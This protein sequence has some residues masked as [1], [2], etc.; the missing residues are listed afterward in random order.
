[1]LFQWLI[2]SNRKEDDRLNQAE[3]ILVVSLFSKLYKW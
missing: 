2:L 1:M 3:H